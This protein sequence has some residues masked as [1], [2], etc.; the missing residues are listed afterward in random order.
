MPLVRA[1]SFSTLLVGICAAAYCN[2]SPGEPSSDPV[3]AAL[4]GSWTFVRGCGG[5]DGGC[6]QPADFSEPTRYRF[7]P[8]DTV[9]AYAGTSLL[10]RTRFTITPGAA[11]GT[12]DERPTL[13]I[14]AV[15]T[16]DPRPLR[17]SFAGDT[18]LLDEG[19]CDRYTFAY[20]R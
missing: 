17:I 1:L 14:G 18:L 8:D 5:L 2:A 19:C 15:E 10:Y 4:L 11:P 13:H 12:G 16:A 7:R 20:V 6:R 3:R 9:E